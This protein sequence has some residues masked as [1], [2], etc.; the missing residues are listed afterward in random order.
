[1]A[2]S[3]S[4]AFDQLLAR[5]ELTSQQLITIGLHVSAIDVFLRS[6][7]AMASKS[8]EIGSAARQ[9]I[10]RGE[11]DIDILAPFSV[12]QYWERFRNDSRQFL[13]WV[14]NGLND[15]YGKTMVSSKQVAVKI[16]F[17]DIVADVVPSFHR[18]GGG[19]FIPNGRGGWRATNPPFHSDLIVRAD[20][21]E[22]FSSS[23]LDQ[24]SQSLEFCQRAPSHFLSCGADGRAHEEGTRGRPVVSRSGGGYQDPAWLALEQLF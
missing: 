8:I 14:R 24:A 2:R 10:C 23:S 21:R 5:Q 19:Y 4:E 3:V 1:M 6:N 18:E 11:R 15:H 16:D 12:P 9:T 22:E 7:Y 17:S 13:Y 20:A